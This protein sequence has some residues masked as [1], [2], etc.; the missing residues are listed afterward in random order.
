MVAIVPRI[1][2]K[3]R[4]RNSIQRVKTEQR[5]ASIAAEYTARLPYPPRVGVGESMNSAVAIR[6]ARREECSQLRAHPA[7][8]TAMLANTKRLRTAQTLGKDSMVANR[9]W[10]RAKYKR[11]PKVK[12][13]FKKKSAG[14]YSASIARRI[15]GI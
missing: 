10:N 9:A 14:A 5:N 7:V 3:Y 12:L 15:K 8:A 4:L 13:L 1:A 11:G 2:L 6:A